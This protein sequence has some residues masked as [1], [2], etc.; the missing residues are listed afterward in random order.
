MTIRSLLLTST[1]ALAFTL[2]PGVTT[3][4]EPAMAGSVG[5][6]GGSTEITQLLNNTQLVGIQSANLS[7]LTQQV[8][9]VANQIT[10]IQHLL[11]QYNN[12][13]QNTMNLPN[14]LWGNIASTLNSLASAV[15]QGQALA[16]SVSNIDSVIRNRFG[17]YSVYKTSPLNSA[18]FSAKYDQWSTTNQD[19]IA[20]AMKAAELQY[21][22]FANESTRL[23]AIQGMSES[24]DGI[25]K[26]IQVGNQIAV[27]QAQQMMKL[28]QLMMSQMQMTASFG[29][30]YTAIE[31]NQQ[32]K[33][34]DYF[35]TATRPTLNDGQSF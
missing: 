33:R 27:E 29:S 12:M 4:P 6:F 31:D 11:N 21:Q 25:H 16:Y 7:Q 32:A 15:S 1:L 2:D 24:S 3:A 14:H 18:K 23:A 13:V 22:D 35:K 10:Q 28:R 5:G 34:D 26:A 8:Q 20:G 30:R 9:M 19:S 17:N